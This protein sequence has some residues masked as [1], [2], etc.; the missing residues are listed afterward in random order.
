VLELRLARTERPRVTAGT[1]A[2]QMLGAFV[3]RRS[4]APYRVEVLERE[5]GHL[6]AAEPV[7]GSKSD[8][9]QVLAL[10]R[11]DLDALDEREF[12]RRWGRRRP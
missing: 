8:A 7:D 4:F 11:N 6:V 9:H 1:V 12:L 2:S 5:R 3:R 10:M